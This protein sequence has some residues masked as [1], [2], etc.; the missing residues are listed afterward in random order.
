MQLLMLNLVACLTLGLNLQVILFSVT[1][2]LLKKSLQD[3][4]Y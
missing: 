3:F 4:C 1:S 2:S